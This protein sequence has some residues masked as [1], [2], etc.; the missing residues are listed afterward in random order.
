V[1]PDKIAESGRPLQA[2]LADRISGAMEQ[3]QGDATG[4]P[5]TVAKLQTSFGNALA[6]LGQ[7]AKAVSLLEGALDT[8][9]EALGTDDPLTLKSANDLVKALGEAREYARAEALAR[10]V[11]RRAGDSNDEQV[12]RRKLVA[13]RALPTLLFRQGKEAEAIAMGREV[14]EATRALDGPDAEQ[15]GIVINS[16]GFMHQQAGEGEDAVRLFEEAGRIFA[17]TLPPEHPTRLALL[18]NLAS[19]Y[20]SMGKL[21]RS[22]PIFEE[23]QT[24]QLESLGPDHINTRLTS[25]N[26]G[27]NYA[28]AGSCE[29]A[30]VRLE[31]ACNAAT[32]N[33][34]LSFAAIP[35][36]KCYIKTGRADAARSFA[37]SL[38][39]LLKAT[40]KPGSPTLSDG[41]AN[42]AAAYV[43]EGMPA[44]AEPFIRELDAMSGP[45]MWRTARSRSWLAEKLSDIAAANADA[46]IE[47]RVRLMNE[48]ERLVMEAV[49]ET[50]PGTEGTDSEP[51]RAERAEYHRSA[52]V[53]AAMIFKARN[54]L[55]PNKGYDVQ[56]TEWRKKAKAL[57]TAP[58]GE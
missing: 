40:E 44:E 19:A 20:W 45:E 38:L 55:E 4:D 17:L 52:T 6:A 3:L 46:S 33:P 12:R 2:V 14:V 56:A 16:L 30:I 54:T 24:R 37:P 41:L 25:A 42:A 13:M 36:L 1:R 5:L 8:R 31:L 23:L 39:T 22:I 48:S 57:E 35:L 58:K 7:S 15:T 50:K 27:V 9:T 11:I 18:N 51:A 34:Q 32:K 29:E 21:D 26:L 47:D 43:D 49:E 53:R 10:D 28:S